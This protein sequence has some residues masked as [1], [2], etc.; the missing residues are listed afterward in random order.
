MVVFMVTGAAHQAQHSMAVRI[1][2]ITSIYS[3]LDT[4]RDNADT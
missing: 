2:R 4:P 3:Q 1:V